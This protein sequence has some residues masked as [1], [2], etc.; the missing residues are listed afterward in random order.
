MHRGTE[1]RVRFLATGRADYGSLGHGPR[2]PV[3][4]V[5]VA[6]GDETAHTNRL[7]RA[8]ITAPIGKARRHP[9]KARRPGY[10]AD[11]VTIRL[12]K[13][14]KRGGSGAKKHWPG[15]GSWRP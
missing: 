9:A 2:E 15:P 10:S 5:R 7:G 14:G 11:V 6:I 13:Q 12:G 4:E 1:V 3:A 8:T